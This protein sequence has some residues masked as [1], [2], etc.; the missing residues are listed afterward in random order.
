MIARLEMIPAEGRRPGVLRSEFG[1]EGGENGAAQSA[2]PFL[3]SRPSKLAQQD[4]EP[5]DR[6]KIHNKR[7]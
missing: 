7:D 4:P 1:T 3:C 6:A 2:T 5:T